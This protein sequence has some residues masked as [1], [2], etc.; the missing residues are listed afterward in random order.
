MKKRLLSLLLAVITV[1]S[2]FS[3]GSTAFAASNKAVFDHYSKKGKYKTS[4]FTFT[5]PDN[6]FTYKVWYPKDI[7]KM[8]KRPVILYCNGTG[9]NY[10]KENR[11][12]EILTIAASYGYICLCNT[13]TNTGTGASMDA[14]MTR[15]IKYNKTKGS[16]LYNKVNTS[17][18]GL[19]GHSQ[20]ATCTV[21][22]SDP[23]QY[24]NSKCY[25]AIYA[26]S[27]PTN[28]LADSPLQECPYDSTKVKIPTC[29]VAGT[30]FT[31]SKFICPM[32]TSL[33]PN[34]ANI[35]SDVYMARKKDVEHAGSFEQMFPYM[36][37]W[38]DYQFFADE[39]AAKAFTGKK[40]EL[41]VNSEWQDFKVKIKKKTATVK[42]VKA[43][44][45]AFKV[46]YKQQNTASG[47]KVEYSTNKNFKNKKTLT[48]KGAKTVSATVKK[49]KSGRTYYVR[50][51]SYIRVGKKN[52]YSKYSAVTEVKVK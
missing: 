14:G 25:K 15:L 17:K 49:L 46:S 29:L 45:K 36:L 26:A 39:F 51:R 5:L 28:A 2:V 52:Y 22:L 7:K 32:D 20:G 8:S 41:K 21:N 42:S 43:K 27:L 16:R 50:V 4:T 24:A 11:T 48:V 18:V 1:L 6:D 34:F 30:G 31:D 40:P 19:A 9:S 13:D 10:E 3:V 33:K 44:K 23:A 47:Y 35:D 37:A 12:S 38:F